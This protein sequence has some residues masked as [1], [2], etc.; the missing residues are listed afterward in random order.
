MG[1]G[2]DEDRHRLVCAQQVVMITIFANIVLFVIKI[3]LSRLSG[4]V[5]ILGDAIHTFT[6]VITSM[7]IIYGIT[8]GSRPPDEEHPF[9]HGAAEDISVL[10]VGILLVLGGGYLL[11]ESGMRLTDPSDV[12]AG[13]WI[14]AA[15]VL[16]I[17]IKEGAARYSERRGHQLHCH[18]LVA[19]AWHH[20]LDAVSSILVLA[21]IA[22]VGAGYP[23]M[24]G[25]IGIPMAMIV[26]YVA[27]KITAVPIR[28]LMSWQDPELTDMVI[29]KAQEVQGVREAHG[30]SVQS[31]GNNKRIALHILVDPGLSVTRA[32]EIATEV[33]RKLDN[34]MNAF[35]AVHIEPF[36]PA[37]RSRTT[38]KGPHKA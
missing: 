8:W 14:I 27:V 16:T 33:E 5:S 20:R 15:V 17:G 13:P 31:I 25:V 23:W 22:G 4:S 28:N 9:G 38:G 19:D 10:V 37:G 24:D 1:A 6:D 29:K 36:Q 2:H 32:H 21:A 3:V 26:L 11:L 35:T 12:N 7:V 34:E 18:G 30:V